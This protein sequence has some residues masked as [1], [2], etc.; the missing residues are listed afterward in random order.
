V[1]TTPTETIQQF[2]RSLADGDL[3]SLIQLY[4]PE[5][6]FSPRPG[7]VV[8]GTAAIGAALEQFLALKPEMDGEVEK[9]I[10]AG[11]VA[12][13]A[14]RW[15][16]RGRQPGGESIEMRGTSADVMRRRPD[17]TWGILIDDPWG[18]A[19]S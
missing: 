15:T 7:E 18:S 3:E 19:A 8:T 13:V 11:D 12:L 10:E 16:L 2:S 17:G 9:V 5:A 4:E 1:S 6:S 14:N